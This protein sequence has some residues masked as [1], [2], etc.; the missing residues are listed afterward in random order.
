MSLTN[1][2]V[3]DVRERDEFEQEHI[4]GSIN[5]PLTEMARFESLIPVL[6]NRKVLLMCRSGR[7]AVIANDVF[8][9]KGIETEIYEGGIL[10]W[11]SEG[12]PLVKSGKPSLPL[13][14]Q[15]L[16]AVGIFTALFSWLSYFL[17]TYFIAGLGLMSMG[18]LFAGITG[19]CMLMSLL[20]KMP[21]NKVSR[22]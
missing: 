18:L 21:W 10:R 2:I 22:V 11:K 20:R 5:L 12:K 9:K 17:D 3:I 7:R 13:F 19:H 4:S 6:T 16:I 15:V 1:E 8:Q 14:R